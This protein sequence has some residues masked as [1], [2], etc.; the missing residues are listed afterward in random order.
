MREQMMSNMREH[1]IA[2]ND[3]QSALANREYEKAAGI[4]KLHM[5]M[6]S[7]A[8]HH[9]SHLAPFM[10]REMQQIGTSM[11]HAASRF[12]VLVAQE[13]AVDQDIPRAL[14]SLAEVTQQ[15]VACHAAYRV[16]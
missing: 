1:L 11:H 8:G 14:R 6:S 12:A 15:C 2:L 16:H 13:T 7:P 3:I 9:A 10:P 4:A 5:G